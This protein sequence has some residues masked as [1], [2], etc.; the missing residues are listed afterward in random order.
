MVKSINVLNGSDAS[1][2]GSKGANGIIL[3]TLIGK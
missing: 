3:I 2:Y 1:I